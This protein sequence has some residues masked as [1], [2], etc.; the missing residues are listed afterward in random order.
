MPLK[1]VMFLLFGLLCLFPTQ[2]AAQEFEGRQADSLFPGADHVYYWEYSHFPR[3]IHF[4]HVQKGYTANPSL[5]FQKIYKL[6]S[7]YTFRLL[8]TEKDALHQ[9]HQHYEI[10]YLG[11][12]VDGGT[13]TAHLEGGQL[14]SIDAALFELPLSLAPIISR[15]EAIQKAIENKT[16]TTFIWNDPAEEALLKELKRDENASYSPQPKLSWFPIDPANPGGL[17]VLSYSMNIYSLEPLFHDK[18][19]VNAADGSIL[20][21][22]NL[23]HDINTYGTAVTRYSGTQTIRVDSMSNGL[24]RLRDSSLGAQIQTFDLNKSTNYA[25]AVDFIDSNNVWNTVNTQQDEIATDAHWGAEKTYLYFF[26]NYGRQSF[27]NQGA[28]IRSYVHYSNNYNN[29]FWNGYYMTY[30]DGNGTVFTPLT[31]LDVCGHE[32]GHAV[33]TYTANLIYQNESGALNESF[34]DIFGNSIEFENKSNATWKIGEEITPNGSGLRNMEKPKLKGDPDTYKGQYWYNGTGDNGGV[35]TNSGVQNYW[36]YTL[37][38]GDTGTNDKG[39]FYEVDSLGRPVTQQITYRSLSVYLSRFSNYA[40]ARFFSILAAKDLHGACSREVIAV[41]NAWYAVGVGDEY[42]SLVVTANFSSENFQCFS[43]AAISFLN[44]SENARTYLWDF[45]DNSQDTSEHPIHTYTSYGFFDVSLIAYSCYGTSSDTL[46][47]NQQIYIDSTADICH[48]L[49]LPDN[50]RSQSVYCRGLIYD[51]GGESAYTDMLESYLTITTPGADSIGILFLEFDYEANYDYLYLYQGHD[52][53]GVLLGQ[54]SGTN[55][56][57]NGDTLF[58]QGNSITLHHSSDPAVIG[59]GFKLSYQGYRA[60]ISISTPPDSIVCAGD[61]LL[62]IPQWQAADSGSLVFYWLDSSSLQTLN[63][64]KQA[65]LKPDSS[66]TFALVLFDACLLSSDTA[67]FHIQVREPLSLT[68]TEDTLFC[69]LQSGQ[70]IASGSGGLNSG[71]SYSWP[72][73]GLSGASVQVAFERDTLIHVVLSDGCSSRPDTAAIAVHVRDPLSVR[74]SGDTVLCPNSSAFLEIQAS[75]GDSTGYA[76]YWNGSVSPEGFS[77]F[78]PYNQSGWNYVRLRDQ[79][80]LLPAEDSLFIRAIPI[81]NFSLSPDSILCYGQSME[82]HVQVHAAEFP[83][84]QFFWNNAAMATDSFH[85]T[86]PYQ[87][88]TYVVR[89]TDPCTSLTDSVFVGKLAPLTFVPEADTTI[90]YQEALYKDLE[91]SGGN[92]A[93][94]TFLWT[95]GFS[96]DKRSWTPSGTTGYEVVLGDGCSLSDT[97]YF[98]VN[99]RDPLSVE[100]GTNRVVCD[101]MRFQLTAV[102]SGGLNANYSYYWNGIKRSDTASFT[103]SLPKWYSIRLRDGCSPDAFDSVFVDIQAPPIPPVLYSDTFLCTGQEIDV[104]LGGT[105]SAVNWQTSDGM[106][107][108]TPSWKHSWTKAGVYSLTLAIEDADGCKADTLFENYIHVVQAA[109]ARFLLNRTSMPLDEA[110]VQAVSLDPLAVSYEW[111]FSDGSSYSGP[112]V[113]HQFLD[114]GIYTLSLT[115]QDIAGCEDAASDSVSVY[116]KALVWLPNAFTPNAD[117]NNDFY[118]PVFLN[119]LS[120]EYWIYDRWGAL[121]YHCEDIHT[122]QWSGQTRD[123]AEAPGGVYLILFKGQSVQSLQV[124]QNSTLMLIR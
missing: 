33:T 81:L 102:A 79:C 64:G 49:I 80:S 51:D 116:D 60:D 23:L 47:R 96:G 76:A 57:N 8:R 38:E 26:T 27:D 109:E 14:H 73:L 77:T 52:S 39:F 90:C 100:L 29:A 5:F 17:W 98:Q 71:Y 58:I 117:R 63:T 97:Q 4:K 46:I 21:R 56:P 9:E 45:G 35:H 67:W 13:L 112:S 43:P 69:H 124:H 55:L 50:G 114:T 30:G 93:A 28:T 2:S 34:S 42:D 94:Y 82:L 78:I 53:D 32:I 61:S 86:D 84:L 74:L 95:D 36:Y 103:A 15:E 25:N 12:P 106:I 11:Y 83:G 101:A 37:C 105:V 88:G 18:V 40:D 48:A 72:E 66:Q 122:C 75:G 107:F 121:V 41:T 92:Q 104:N 59:T 44:Y 6:P 118:R 110:F 99:V 91:A 123:G 19:Y 31:C 115:V 10:L 87:A 89:V 108:T 62:V 22:E 16:S 1:H 7:A 54:Y 85:Q 68:S 113:N 111:Y 65:W 24:Y 20:F 70:L 120:G 3:Y 119:L